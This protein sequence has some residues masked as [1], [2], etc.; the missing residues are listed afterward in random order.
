M[1]SVYIIQHTATKQI[2]I[3][4]TSDLKNRLIYHNSGKQYSTKRKNGE[5]KYIYIEVY[6]SKK[7]AQ[8]RERK[9]KYYGS[10]KQKLLKRIKNSMLKDYKK[11]WAQLK[12][13][14]DCLAKT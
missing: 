9:L 1:W 6:R 14:G 8:N 10:S 5:W 7:D 13:P 2:Y 4:F 11:G 12:S 3:G